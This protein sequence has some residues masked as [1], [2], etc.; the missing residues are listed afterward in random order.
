MIL[1]LY[2]RYFP[3]STT[4]ANKAAIIF[5]KAQTLHLEKRV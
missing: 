2:F 4:H 1:P 5:Q 3:Y